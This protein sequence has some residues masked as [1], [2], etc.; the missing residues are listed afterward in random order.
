MF[1][2]GGSPCWEDFLAIFKS[3]DSPY[4][5]ERYVEMREVPNLD[6]R[7]FFC[8]AEFSKENRNFH[9]RKVSVYKETGV[10]HFETYFDGLRED[11]NFISFEVT[12][13]LISTG[14]HA[15]KNRRIIQMLS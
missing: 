13:S 3:F 4:F 5:G 14:T 10:V 1:K 12:K 2:Y 9:G 11:G 7:P 15:L 6:G 8:I